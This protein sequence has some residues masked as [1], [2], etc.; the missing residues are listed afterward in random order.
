MLYPLAIVVSEEG[1]AE[2]KGSILVKADRDIK[3]INDLKGKTFLFGSAHNTPK[4]FAAYVTLKKSGIDPETDLESYDLGGE[5][6]KNAM[7]IFLGE[8]DAGVVCKDFVE[9]EEGKEKFNF[10]TDLKVIAGCFQ[11]QKM[12]IV[13]V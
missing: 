3:S 1:E 11:L 8:Y 7:S 9:G 6:E 10:Q 5:C 2:E 4:F 12:L 13:K